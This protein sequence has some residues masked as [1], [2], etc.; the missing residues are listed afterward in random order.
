MERFSKNQLVWATAIIGI[1]LIGSWL[2]FRVKNELPQNTA[3]VKRSN[4]TQEVS[5]IGRVKPA[6]TLDLSVEKSGRIQE[7][8]ARVGSR[9]SRGALLVEIESGNAY[10]SL[11]E[12]E[13]RLAELKRGS[14]PEEV[15]VK[16]AELAKYEQDLL[17]TY[18]GIIDTAIDSFSKA[19]DALHTKT[20]GIFSGFKTTSYK[21]TYQ[22]C[23]SQLENE[24]TTLKT[25][26]ENDFDVWRAEIATAT[27]LS[28]E[29]TTQKVLLFQTGTHLEVTK[30][31]LE[32]ISSTLTLD[33]TVSLATL[34][35]Y[36]ANINTARTNINTAIATI[37][38]K[39]QSIASLERTIEKTK[40]ELALLH[41]GTAQEVIA[42]QEA[43]VI[44]AQKELNKYKIYAPISGMI[45]AIEAHVGEYANA[46]TPLVSIIS[47]ASFEIEA[48]IPEADIA[49]IHIGE[50]AQITLDAYG[51]DVLFE[52][53]VTAIDPAETIIENVPTYKV[54][55]FFTKSDPRIK[56][57][58]TANIDVRTARKDSVLTIPQRAIISKNGTKFVLLVNNDSSTTEVPITTGLRGSD[59]TIE[60]MEGLKEG[61]VIIATPK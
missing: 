17:N 39:K 59:G 20:A 53:S 9:V 58:M 7:I 26:T 31:L 34:D 51:D 48:H 8:S 47:D 43:R 25:K 50:Q 18:D 28:K 15:A 23:D 1:I 57:G 46:S 36:R 14:R 30:I 54:T 3:V 11:L 42:A 38:T 56:S 60:V 27:S 61:D 44:G 32:N 24:T 35:T 45:T 12:A 13:A 21:F 52:G 22:I 6:K 4:L 37:N 49:K 33:C 2:T 5:V 16:E 10:A 19:D 41:A 29:G 40:T 55:F